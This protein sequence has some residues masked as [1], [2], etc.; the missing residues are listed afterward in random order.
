MLLRGDKNVPKERIITVLRPVGGGGVTLSRSRLGANCP[1]L[2]I[3]CCI[4]PF[5]HSEGETRRIS[6]TVNEILRFA[7]HDK[8]QTPSPFRRG[9]KGEVLNLMQRRLSPHPQ[10]LSR[11][12]R[13]VTITFSSQ[14][15]VSAGR[16]RCQ[17][18]QEGV[19]ND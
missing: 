3:P 9:I 4:Y 8:K 6:K 2:I 17:S 1:A 10:P 11:K 12:A 19:T 13:G 15:K 14:E 7:K 16:M 5:R 18:S